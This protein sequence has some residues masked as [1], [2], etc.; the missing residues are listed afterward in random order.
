[1]TPFEV[2]QISPAA[3]QDEAKE[4]YHALA[5][6]WHPD[7]FSGPEK[8]AAEEQFREITEAYAKI[9]SG[10]AASPIAAATGPKS[11]QDWLSEAQGGLAQKNYDLAISLSQFCFQFSEIAEHA[12]LLYAKALEETGRD[13]KSRTR[14]YEEVARVNPNNAVAVAKLAELYKELNMPAK[15]E[16]MAKRARALGGSKPRNAP[17]PEKLGAGGIVGKFAGFFKRG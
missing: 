2:L 10:S 11:P 7:K 8:A 13:L 15:A 9:K 3:S 14:A 6:K 4:A 5:K 1:M 12:R 17:P 16:G